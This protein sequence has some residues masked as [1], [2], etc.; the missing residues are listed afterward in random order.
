MTK[1]PILLAT[2]LASATAQASQCNISGT[3]FGAT[4]ASGMDLDGD[5][6]AARSG[7]LRARGS[8]FAYVDVVVDT[9]LIG[10]CTGGVE[11][12]PSGHA[13][14]ST[15]DGRDAVFATIDSSRHLCTGALETVHLTIT[16]GRGAY[17][18][19]TGTASAQFPDDSVLVASPVGF[20]RMVYTHGAEF[21]VRVR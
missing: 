11:I 21:T 14:W 16:G 3:L 6:N 2:I 12:E 9:K 7:T 17:A 20:P 8:V 1:L 18:G 10:P 5:G 4:F 19:A 15:L 13:V